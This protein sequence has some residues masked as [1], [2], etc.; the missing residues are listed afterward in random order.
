MN[1]RTVTAELIHAD[2][3]TDKHGAAN[4]RFYSRTIGNF[5]V[6]QKQDTFHSFTDSIEV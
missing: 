1:V 2:G 3:R 6:M 5:L 4:S